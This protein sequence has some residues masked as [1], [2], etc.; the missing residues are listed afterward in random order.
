MV[1]LIGVLQQ[2]WQAGVATQ[3]DFALGDVLW[4][5]SISEVKTLSMNLT[6]CNWQ[7]RIYIHLLVKGIVWNYLDFL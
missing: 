6:G 2:T 1:K 7:W 4:V 5:V 3:R